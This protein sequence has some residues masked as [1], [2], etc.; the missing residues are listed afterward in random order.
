MFEQ[1]FL[2]GVVSF[3]MG[4]YLLLNWYVTK[5]ITVLYMIIL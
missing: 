4:L 2:C 3:G 5:N 1:A